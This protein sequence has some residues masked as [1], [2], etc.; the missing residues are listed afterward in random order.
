MHVDSGNMILFKKAQEL[1]NVKTPE[2]LTERE[3][4]RALRDA[5]IAEEG[6]IKQYEA[7][8]DATDNEDAKKI[9]QDIADEERVHVGELQ[10]L[11]NDMLPDEEKLLEEGEKE[12]KEELDG[13]AEEL[14]EA[15]E[16]QEE[17]EE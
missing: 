5:I 8:V 17:P 12:V 3:L 14:K 7:I 9:L 6:A 13:D 10:K 11:L 1:Q 16:V 4:T 15:E 2:P